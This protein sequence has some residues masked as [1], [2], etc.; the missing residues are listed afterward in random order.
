MAM[1]AA[2]MAT[3][4]VTEL[5]TLNADITGAQETLLISYWTKI[6]K[7]ILDEFAANSVV[8]PGS[9]NTLDAQSSTPEPVI[10]IGGPVT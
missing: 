8:A 3:K 7:G 9:F 6:S 2:G 4:I 1:T 5:K 10:G